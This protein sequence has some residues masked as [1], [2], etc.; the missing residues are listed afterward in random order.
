MGRPRDIPEDDF[1]VPDSRDRWAWLVLLGPIAV[2]LVLARKTGASREEQ[3]T[4]LWMGCVLLVLGAVVCSIVVKRR[5]NPAELDQALVNAVRDFG[6]IRPEEL[7]E[8]VGQGDSRAFRR[9]VA[10]LSRAGKLRRTLD[11]IEAP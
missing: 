7:A 5:P 11:G 3:Q 4:I 1:Q 8:K 9:R 10:L 2:F 6:P